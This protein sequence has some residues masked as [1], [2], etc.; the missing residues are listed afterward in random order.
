MVFVFCC[1]SRLFGFVD[2]CCFLFSRG[3]LVFSKFLYFCCFLEVFSFLSSQVIFLFC[4]FSL[5]FL[6]HCG[7]IPFRIAVFPVRFQALH[8]KWNDPDIKEFIA[9]II[10]M[11]VRKTESFVVLLE[12]ARIIFLSK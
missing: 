5:K 1:F 7:T 12:G 11:F 9:L 4:V 6:F 2:I 3:F 10:V 8:K